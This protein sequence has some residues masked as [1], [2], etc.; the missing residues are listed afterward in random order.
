M[1]E[2][3]KH[4]ELF[5]LTI[6]ISETQALYKHFLFPPKRIQIF[7]VFIYCTVQRVQINTRRHK[8]EFSRNAKSMLEKKLKLLLNKIQQG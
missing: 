1:K 3:Q 7:W 6:K 8:I 2:N 5:A 4:K